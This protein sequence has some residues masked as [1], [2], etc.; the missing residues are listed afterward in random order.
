MKKVLLIFVAVLSYVLTAVAEPVTENEAREKAAQFILSMKG[1]TSSARSAQRFDGAKLTA[2]EAQKEFYVFNINSGDGFVIVSGDDCVG[3][4]LVLGYTDNGSFDATSVPE[5]MQWWLNTT[6]GAIARLKDLGVKATSVP[7]HNDIAP[8]LTT[9][10]GQGSNTYDPEKPYN[11]YCPETD[12]NL[13]V[14][15]CMA[16]AL[17]Q[18]MNY[19]RWPQGEMANE[20]PAYTMSDGRIIDALPVTTFDWDNMM[21]DYFV[22]TTE[23][24]QNAVALL[25]R[26]CGQS[27]QMDYS[28][29]ISYGIFYDTDLLANSFG[30]DPDAYRAIPTDY[31][32]SE[33]DELLYNELHEKRPVLYGGSGAM[34]GHAFVLD[35]YEVQDGEGYFHVNW[36]WNG[37]DD[38]FYKINLLNPSTG[39]TGVTSIDDGF[40]TGQSA[41]IGLQPLRDPSK[42]FHR[43]IYGF[44]WDVKDGDIEDEFI[45][46]NI[47]YRPGVFTVG[48][49]ERNDDGTPD[50]SSICYTDDYEVD[51]YDYVK[52]SNDKSGAVFFPLTENLFSNLSSG[53]H[54][55]MFVSRESG[56]T[57]PWK[58]V[59]GPSSYIEVNI[60]DGGEV[61]DLII[62]PQPQLTSFSAGIEIKGLKQCHIAQTVK[63][64]IR[65]NAAAD[66]FIGDL[67][68]C[69][70]YVEDGKL[71][72]IAATSNT[73]AVIE[74]GGKA[75]VSFKM[76]VP[77]IGDYVFLIA[78]N[79]NIKDI[80][81]TDV[82]DINQ[83]S[84]YLGHKIAA[85]D[86]LAFECL[87][88]R[89][90]EGTDEKGN[91]DY[92]IG[93]ILGNG[94]PMDYDAVLKID[95]YKLN[96]EGT[97]EPV[98]PETETLYSKCQIISGTYNITLIH[99]PEHLE[100]GAY[101]FDIFIAN[102]FHSIDKRDYFCLTTWIIEV[103]DPTEI[104]DVRCEME[105]RGSGNDGWY[106][107]NG[108][109]LQGKPTKKGIYIHKGR[110]ISIY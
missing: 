29:D 67:R 39:G 64:T 68:C 20:L 107:L 88:A 11:A 99:L 27:I 49:A 89:Y 72:D 32:L 24:Q 103:D 31:S 109:L 69:A 106:D 78:K 45:M 95:L 8:M 34:G 87:G 47:S 90:A 60:G 22:S 76:S 13:C 96:D 43:Y 1:N 63:A 42:K 40:N 57:A 33:W 15:G 48:L 7:T 73:R 62:H 59:Y 74:A 85:F 23:E 75:D 58:P 35:G 104:K 108:R 100:S 52:F 94:T 2:V 16:T 70:F 30:Y 17:A 55:L 102:D 105:E 97:P 66:D 37:G 81:G 56:T 54:K 50:L 83:V 53:N 9:K 3:D 4:N 71:I 10:W 101:L 41:L 92:V 25:M 91:P 36:G 18:V 19:H 5:N 98:L 79:P 14:T 6:A 51:G 77:W 84:G 44:G 80:I 65:N 26:Y 86:K 12:G 61:T 93:V 38:G 28:P 46:V 21:D 110:K 82:A